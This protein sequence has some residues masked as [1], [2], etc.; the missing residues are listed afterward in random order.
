MKDMLVACLDKYRKSTLSNEELAN[1]IWAYFMTKGGWHMNLSALFGR[2][3]L[4]YR[5]IQMADEVLYS[6]DS[7]PELSTFDPA[8]PLAPP[9]AQ[10]KTK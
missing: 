6:G 10:Q 1:I 9:E 3:A 5:L 2:K 4:A 7:D 8:S